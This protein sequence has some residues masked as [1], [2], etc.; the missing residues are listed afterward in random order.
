MT[1]I[2]SSVS[3]DQRARWRLAVGLDCPTPPARLDLQAAR[4][5][6]GA[7]ASWRTSAD[8]VAARS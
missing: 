3:T 1:T 5:A 6:G 8:V 4:Y 7:D 2:E